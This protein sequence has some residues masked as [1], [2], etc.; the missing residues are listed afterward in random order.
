MRDRWMKKG[1]VTYYF[2]SFMYIFMMQGLFSLVVN[3]AVL[4]ISAYSPLITASTG[5]KWSD[6]LGFAVSAAGLFTES[7]ADWQLT[8]HIKNP[9]PKKGKFC[10]TGLWRYS[11][12]PNYFGETVVWWG[13]WIS[14]CSLPKG[15]MTMYA[16]AFIT[17][18]LLRL[19]GVPL[20]EKKQSQHPEW[21]AYSSVTTS[22]FVPWLPATPK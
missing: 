8:R 19:S 4:H 17:W 15:W 18:L 1:K 20:L 11:R 7:L 16:P 14:A 13:L 12:H 5:L 9:D 2:N 21:A 22:S 3:G 6:Y 10:N